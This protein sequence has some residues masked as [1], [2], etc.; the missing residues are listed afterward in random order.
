[1]YLP[2]GMVTTLCSG[3]LGDARL[4]ELERAVIL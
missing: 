2:S 3:L 1:V 4:R